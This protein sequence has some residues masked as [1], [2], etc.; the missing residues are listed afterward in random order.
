MFEDKL[1]KA[2]KQLLRKKINMN[3]QDSRVF[4]SVFLP[5]TL[6]LIKIL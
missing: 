6:T 3:G 5:L 4:L 1:V 2:L